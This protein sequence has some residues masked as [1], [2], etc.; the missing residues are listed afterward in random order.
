MKYPSIIITLVVS[1]SIAALAHSD[2]GKDSQDNGK[3]ATEQE[4]LK[5][6]KHSN[7]KDKQ[8]REEYEDDRNE[9]AKEGRKKTED[10]QAAAKSKGESGKG[11]GEEKRAANMNDRAR[12]AQENKNASRQAKDDYKASVKNGESERVKGKK[13]WWKIWGSDPE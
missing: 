8:H 9:A 2:P 12:E 6:N 1:F 10:Q 7:G 4:M 11:K 3:Q 5:A 13:P